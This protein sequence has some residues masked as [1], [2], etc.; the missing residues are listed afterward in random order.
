MQKNRLGNFPTRFIIEPLIHGKTSKKLAILAS[1]F[2][3]IDNPV[4]FLY[5]GKHLK[6]VH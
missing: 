1:S 4:S 2:R 5:C 3:L 6:Y